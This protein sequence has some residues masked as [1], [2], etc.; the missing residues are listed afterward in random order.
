MRYITIPEP[1]SDL[2]QDR[3]TGA[4]VSY[5]FA[6]YLAQFVF[7]NNEAFRASNDAV[8]SLRRIVAALGKYET[9]EVV[10]IESEDYERLRTAACGATYSPEIVVPI[11]CNFVHAI[12]SAKSEP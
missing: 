11:T 10:S 7:S 12:T 6:S 9:G 2:L 3:S 8:E 1:I 4:A 5:S